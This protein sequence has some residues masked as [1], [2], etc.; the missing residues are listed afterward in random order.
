MQQSLDAGAVSYCY[1][2]LRED[3]PF[4]LGPENVPPVMSIT[5]RS[6]RGVEPIFNVRLSGIV[7]FAVYKK[8]SGGGSGSAR[9]VTANDSRKKGDN[10]IFSRHE[11]TVD[12]SNT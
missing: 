12:S 11:K 1:Q 10:N 2:N 5:R 9:P 7:R 3:S 6:P 4:N 8:V